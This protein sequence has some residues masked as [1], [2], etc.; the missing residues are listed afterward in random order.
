MSCSLGTGTHC[1]AKM[2]LT[3]CCPDLTTVI[4]ANKLHGCA[5]SLGVELGVAEGG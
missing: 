5:Y 3:Q 2:L 1:A 4:L